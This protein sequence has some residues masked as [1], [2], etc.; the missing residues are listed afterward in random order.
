ML[1]LLLAFCLA[2]LSCG[3][4]PNDDFQESLLLRPLADGKVLGH[5]QFS[6]TSTLPT[7]DA[8]VPP[9]SHTV[10]FPQP[11]GAILHKYDVREMHLQL[12]HGRWNYDS[13]GLPLVSAPI[14]AEFWAWTPGSDDAAWAGLTNSLSGLLGV[15]LG[16]LDATNTRINGTLFAPSAHPA[17][18]AGTAMRHGML[19]REAFCTENLAPWLK[20][21]P[22]RQADGLASLLAPLR[23]FDSH[24]FALGLHVRWVRP[25]TVEL[26]QTATVVID[27][28]T[29]EWTVRSRPDPAYM[30]PGLPQPAPR[31]PGQPLG[32]LGRPAAS[33]MPVQTEACCTRPD[34]FSLCP[35]PDRWEE[36]AC[37]S[38]ASPLA[39]YGLPRADIT[40]RYEAGFYSRAYQYDPSRHVAGQTPVAAHRYL[41]GG[42]SSDDGQMTLHLT[43]T[44]P[45]RPQAVVYLDVYPWYMQLLMHTLTV[46]RYDAGALA[47]R[48][49]KAAMGVAVPTEVA[50]PV[51]EYVP[52]RRHAQAALRLEATLPPNST[53]VVTVRFEKA[54]LHVSEHPADAHRGFDI[55]P[56]QVYMV[57]V[58]GEDRCT[59]GVA[60]RQQ[61]DRILT[62]MMLL[63]L[64]VPDFSMPYNVIALATTIMALFFGSVQASLTAQYPKEHPE[65]TFPHWVLRKL[66]ETVGRPLRLVVRRA[67]AAAGWLIRRADEAPA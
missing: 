7:S 67:K 28:R 1:R 20:L 24:H 15:T 47:A 16:G 63:R 30:S 44:D 37:R 58:E 2:A 4:L 13:W 33:A 55:A 27:P 29:P 50:F 18:L 46:R 66:P 51:F 11:L 62:E 59:R 45:A 52:S 12:A 54:F 23:L 22:C 31:G 36:P 39:I 60:P 35:A 9:F 34:A 5:F 26:V 57:P 65:E 53:T 32:R 19:T 41:Y 49:P 40:F 42:G 10:L 43:N 38:G 14:G 61:P 8:A 3:A 64:P 17:L 6:L 21:L 56:G 25:G 48:S